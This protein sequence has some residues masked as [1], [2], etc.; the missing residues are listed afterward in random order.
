VDTAQIFRPFL[1]GYDWEKAK[2][3]AR[4]GGLPWVEL[5]ENIIKAHGVVTKGG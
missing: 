2:K 3:L 4:E 1:F 5:V